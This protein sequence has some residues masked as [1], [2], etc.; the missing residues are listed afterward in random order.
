MISRTKQWLRERHG[1]VAGQDVL[2]EHPALVVGGV[3]VVRGL[4]RGHAQP[5]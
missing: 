4:D 1:A 3:E 2:V 5:Q